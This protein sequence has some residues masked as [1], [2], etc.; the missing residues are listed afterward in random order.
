MKK[1]IYY[2]R[3]GILA[4]MIALIMTLAVSAHEV[5]MRAEISVRSPSGSIVTHSESSLP[6]NANVTSVKI[7][8]RYSTGEPMANGRIQIFAPGNS[9]SP[10]QTGTLNNQGEYTF[11]PNLSQRGRWT[12]RVESEGHSN[13]VN[14]VI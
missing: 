4:S 6:Q 10:W 8:V 11:S 9:S 14:L 2:F 5:G 13:F 7:T 3:I 12:V 1:I